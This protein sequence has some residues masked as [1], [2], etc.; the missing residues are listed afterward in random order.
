MKSDRR[1]RGKCWRGWG[2]PPR[3]G[4]RFAKKP[5]RTI[6]YMISGE[7]VLQWQL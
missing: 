6:C 1:L 7:I 4:F 2:N 3:R 5:F